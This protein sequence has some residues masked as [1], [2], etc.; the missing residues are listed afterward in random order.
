MINLHQILIKLFAKN[1]IKQV[2]LSIFQK[3]K[4]NAKIVAKLYLFVKH[5]KLQMT[6]IH[7]HHA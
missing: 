4:I 3:I 2:I 7:A 6:I 5:V 1:A